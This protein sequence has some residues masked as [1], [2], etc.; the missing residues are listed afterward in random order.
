VLVAG[1]HATSSVKRFEQMILDI[2][3]EKCEHLVYIGIVSTNLLIELSVI[4]Q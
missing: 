1:S 3:S 2:E 4:P